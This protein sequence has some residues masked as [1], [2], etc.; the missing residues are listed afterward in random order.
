MHITP[1]NKLQSR[2]QIH[3]CQLDFSIC[4]PTNQIPAVASKPQGG[5]MTQKRRI[6]WQV[7]P[8]AAI[9][10]VLLISGAAQASDRNGSFTEEFHKVYPFSAQGRIQ[11][12]NL[13]GPVHI[14]AWDRDEVKIEIQAEPS[15]LSIHTEYAGRNHT[16]NFG[17]D[18]EHG[19]PASV[20][21]TITVPR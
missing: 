9:S 7:I 18:N 15:E 20:E 10:A 11:I 19:N 17:G 8:A 13:N 16:F 2:Q 5:V 6:I 21:Y 3:P 12:D 1:H 14:S 4:P